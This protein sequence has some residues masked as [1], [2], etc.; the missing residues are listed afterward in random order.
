MN[1]R[2]WISLPALEARR[3]ARPTLPTY[4]V[5]RD[6]PALLTHTVPSLRAQASPGASA[7]GTAADVKGVPGFLGRLF[8]VKNQ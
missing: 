5:L 8:G 6:A 4:L 2:Q 1:R 3:V 7:P